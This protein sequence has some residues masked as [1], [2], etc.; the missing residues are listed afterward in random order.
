MGQAALK[1]WSVGE[2]FRR[3]RSATLGK[4][5]A[6]TCPILW[7]FST[8]PSVTGLAH[9]LLLNRAANE[10]CILTSPNDGHSGNDAEIVSGSSWNAEAVVCT[11]LLGVTKMASQAKQRLVVIGN[12]M[13]PERALERLF[14]QA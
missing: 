7:I 12:G 3:F 13:A 9:L 14:E 10:G 4:E 5:L 2:F 1:A 6:A 8:I 11:F